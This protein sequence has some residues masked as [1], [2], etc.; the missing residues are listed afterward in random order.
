MNYEGFKIHSTE[1]IMEA[2]CTNK[3]CKK[4]GEKEMVEVSNGF[5]S[6]AL[7]CPHC[8]SVYVLSLEKVDG[9]IKKN[10]ER[11][12]E[13]IQQ[14]RDKVRLNEL[15]RQAIGQFVLEQTERREK[16]RDKRLSKKRK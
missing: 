16:E 12:A 9:R 15:K 2:Y 3:R 8:E 6:I 5:A 13:F 4:R 10:R 14:C 7:F 1:R 11:Y